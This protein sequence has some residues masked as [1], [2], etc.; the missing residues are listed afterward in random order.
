MNTFYQDEFINKRIFQRL[1]KEIKREQLDK[2]INEIDYLNEL[3]SHTLA[4]RY[5]DGEQKMELDFIKK[6]DNAKQRNI[7]A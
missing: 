7:Q 6:F 1:V 3:M 5:V 2:T 4:S